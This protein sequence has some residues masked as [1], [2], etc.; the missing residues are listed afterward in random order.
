[1][2]NISPALKLTKDDMA[3]GVLGFLDVKIHRVNNQFETSVYRKKTDTCLMMKFDS[4]IPIK[5]K[6]NLVKN[7]TLRCLRICSH[8]NR[9]NQDIFDLRNRLLANGFPNSFI[10]KYVTETKEKFEDVNKSG[11]RQ[12]LDDGNH[13]SLYLKMPYLNQASNWF[14]YALRSCVNLKFQK[15][16]LQPVLTITNRIRDFVRVR[17][18]VPIGLRSNLIYE[19]KCPVCSESYVGETYRQ[20]QI[21]AFEHVGTSWRTGK[22]I[23]TPGISAVNEHILR[24]G[25]KGDMSNFRIVCS[26]Y[27][28]STLTRRI[29]E[30]GCIKKL[31]PKINGN[32]CGFLLKLTFPAW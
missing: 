21:R 12:D 6:R 15:F 31:K 11:I 10:D 22:N 18:E 30:A 26:N 32:N 27:L 17:K 1:M 23:K 9:L 29:L 19:Y 16:K 4:N 5:Y 3:N 2:N 13:K 7:L 8:D 20:L 28:G 14:A 24:T 25:H